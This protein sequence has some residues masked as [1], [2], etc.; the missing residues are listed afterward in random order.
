MD[1]KEKGLKTG[2]QWEGEAELRDFLG[3]EMTSVFI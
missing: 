2:Q 1:N 3:I